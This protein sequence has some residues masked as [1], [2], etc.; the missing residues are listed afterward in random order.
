MPRRAS[1]A[2]GC[3]LERA[4][5]THYSRC[6]RNTAPAAAAA[7][8]GLAAVAAAAAAVAVA[9]AAAVVGLAAAAVAAAAAVVGLS[10]AA[11]AAAA[12][13][14]GL[15]V[16]GAGH[17]RGCVAAL[18]KVRFGP[19]LRM[20]VGVRLV[21]QAAVH[22]ALALGAGRWGCRPNSGLARPTARPTAPAQHR[23]GSRPSPGV[24]MG[25]AQQRGPRW[26]PGASLVLGCPRH[27]RG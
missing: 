22:A 27:C 10:A 12:A 24:P 20:G 11:V 18:A 7:V 4:G 21:A 2:C 3:C 26:P 19:R 13:V 8:A 16:A 14:V 1:G 6:C 9:A 17:A 5:R 23:W 25:P 15:A